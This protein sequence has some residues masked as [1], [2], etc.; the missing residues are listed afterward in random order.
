MT[1]VVIP[2]NLLDVHDN[3]DEAKRCHCVYYID[4]AVPQKLSR[5]NTVT[6]PPNPV[7]SSEKI[8]WWSA[9]NPHANIRVKYTKVALVAGYLSGLIGLLAA[10]IIRVVSYRALCPLWRLQ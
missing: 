5:S 9:P 10:I 7:T 2:K 6:D 3:R 1:N 4:E 8:G